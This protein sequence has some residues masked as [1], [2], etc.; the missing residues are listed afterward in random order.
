MSSP[1]WWQVAKRPKWI[2]GLVFALGVAVI[3]AL[4]GQWQ[5]ERTFTVVEEPNENKA[6]LELTQVATPGEPLTAAAANQRVVASLYLDT[7]NV[8]IVANRLQGESRTNGYWVI[9]NSNVMVE[10]FEKP[11]SL[12]VVLGFSQSLEIAEAARL[13]L[14]DSIQAAAFLPR[15][16]RYIQTEAPT[17]RPD[18]SKPYLL[19]S[20]SLAE[21]V[22]LYSSEPIA[23][24]AGALV[25]EE[26]PGYGLDQVDIVAP[27]AGLEINW[28]TLFYA[29]EWAVFAGF[30]IFLWWRLVED[31]RVREQKVSK[32]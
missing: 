23:S 21:L 12:T 1:T 15:T 9:S 13:E 17:A 32:A 18:T 24:F 30:A 16:G 2:A 22:N 5:L 14:Q 28:L 10:G 25:L 8:F 4:L 31:Q 29:L 6:A 7:S 19:G 26:A 3:F 20:L 27:D 11:A